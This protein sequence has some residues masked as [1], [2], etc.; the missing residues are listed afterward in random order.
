M[1]STVKYVVHCRNHTLQPVAPYMSVELLRRQSLGPQD[2]LVHC[3]WWTSPIYSSGSTFYSRHTHTHTPT[4]AS[5]KLTV[6]N[7]RP[8]LLTEPLPRGGT[9]KCNSLYHGIKHVIRMLDNKQHDRLTWFK[10]AQF[11]EEITEGNTNFQIYS[12]RLTFYNV[13]PDRSQTHSY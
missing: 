8:L 4:T 12:T 2:F 6:M 11:D 7:P 10:G 1:L 13:K 3:T 9:C 5:N